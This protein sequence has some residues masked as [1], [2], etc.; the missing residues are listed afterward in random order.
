MTRNR[1]TGKALAER[2]RAIQLHLAGF[3][4]EEIADKLGAD[5]SV[6]FR[7]LQSARD[8]R[9]S[10]DCPDREEARFNPMA[11]G[12][13][14]QTS[15]TLYEVEA[16]YTTSGSVSLFQCSNLVPRMR[17]HPGTKGGFTTRLSF[18]TAPNGSCNFDM[19]NNE[20]QR[21]FTKTTAVSRRFTKTGANSRKLQQDR[22]IAFSEPQA[23]V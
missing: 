21:S 6:V 23:I 5:R 20:E 16:R 17:P 22:G 9:R 2:R 10:G 14:G 18:G 19:Q 1:R 3:T 13:R 7:D 15:Y 12:K 11:I 4:R 8:A